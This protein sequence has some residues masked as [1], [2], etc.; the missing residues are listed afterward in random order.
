MFWNKVHRLMKLMTEIGLF[1]LVWVVAGSVALGIGMLVWD[2]F[3]PKHDE[4]KIEAKLSDKKDGKSEIT[5][6]IGSVSKRGHLWIAEIDEPRDSYKATYRSSNPIT[7]NLIITPEKSDKVRL[8][9]D[10]Y[11]NKIDSL[12]SLPEYQTED[13]KVIVCKYIKNFND[14]VDDDSAKTSLMLIDPTAEKQKTIVE[15]VDKVLKLDS[16]KDGINVIYFKNGKL[17]NAI[18]NIK[19][20]SLIS[21]PAIFDLK[22]TSLKNS[23]LLMNAN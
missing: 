1:V 6:K 3:K 11:K 7:R 20:Y 2:T 16:V 13:P 8:L 5:L 15:N 9:F 19:D 23:K 22:D 18:Y 12:E 21:E 10:N 14:S 4:V 17:V